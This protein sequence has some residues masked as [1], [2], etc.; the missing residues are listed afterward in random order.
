M[1]IR[2]REGNKKL[3]TSDYG[4]CEHQERME[5][6]RQKHLSHTDAIIEK[7]TKISPNDM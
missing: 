5:V 4:E 1:L 6:S 2:R 7:N 3:K